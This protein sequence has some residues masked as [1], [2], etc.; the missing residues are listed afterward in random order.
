MKNDTTWPA[1]QV[2]PRPVKAGLG[3]HEEGVRGVDDGVKKASPPLWKRGRTVQSDHAAFSD[4]R[5]VDDQNGSQNQIHSRDAASREVSNECSYVISLLAAEY[6]GNYSHNT[7][8][9]T[10]II[11]FS[12][13]GGMDPVD[14]GL[15]TYHNRDDSLMSFRFSLPF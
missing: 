15:R 3:G 4:F 6:R 10:S 9:L 11:L 13:H 7:Q 12:Q 8:Q 1:T 2:G 14:N 5:M